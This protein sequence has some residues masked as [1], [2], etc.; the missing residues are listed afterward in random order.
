MARMPSIQE[1][2]SP[3]VKRHAYAECAEC[4]DPGIDGGGLT[5][6]AIHNIRSSAARMKADLP[7]NF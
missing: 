2:R 4:A 3:G 7:F 6:S 5:A 1:I